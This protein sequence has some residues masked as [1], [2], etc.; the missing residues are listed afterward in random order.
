[1]LVTY[2]CSGTD[3]HVVSFLQVSL[4]FY[5]YRLAYFS[6]TVSYECKIVNYT[7]D[8]LQVQTTR[9]DENEPRDGFLFEPGKN[10]TAGLYYKTFYGR[11]LFRTVV[12]WCIGHFL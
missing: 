3:S 7:G 8:R 9:G 1:M 6:T 5:E 12:H 11:N 10:L 2:Y 4:N